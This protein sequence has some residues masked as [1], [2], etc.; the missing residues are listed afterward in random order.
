MSIKTTSTLRSIASLGAAT[1]A[2]TTLA[3]IASAKEPGPPG[4]SPYFYSSSL[5]HV[6]APRPDFPGSKQ[7][8]IVKV[9]HSSK[10]HKTTAHQ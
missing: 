6:F 5:N 9:S 2:L 4:L 7:S 10:H 3:Q 1:A 8:S